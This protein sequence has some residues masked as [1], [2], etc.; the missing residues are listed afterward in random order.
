MGLISLNKLLIHLK[1]KAQAHTCWQGVGRHYSAVTKTSIFG[2]FVDGYQ[3]Y[4]FQRQP[5]NYFTYRNKYSCQ[6][7]NWCLNAAKF[8]HW[9]QAMLPRLKPKAVVVMDNASYRSRRQEKIPVT[10]WK[11]IDIQ[12]WLSSKQISFEAKEKSSS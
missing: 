1:F 5:A 3:E 2:G 4:Y 8:K 11:K 7:R 9:F 10:S 12:E 6:N